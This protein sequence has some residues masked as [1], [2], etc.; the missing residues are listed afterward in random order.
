VRTV[1]EEIEKALYAIGAIAD[2]NY[3]DFKKIAFN[4]ATRT[5]KRVHALQNVFSCKVQMSKDEDEEIFRAKLNEKLPS[6]VRVFCVVRSSNRFNAKNCTSNREYSY[7]L[8]AFLLTRISDLY[9]GSGRN[10]RNGAQQIPGTTP[11]TTAQ[12]GGAGSTEQDNKE[13]QKQPSS[14]IKII[15]TETEGGQLYENPEAYLHVN[16]DHIPEEHYEK[17]YSY[18]LSEVDK[19]R[20][21]KIFKMFLGSKKYHNFSKEVKPHQTQAMR[22][23]VELSAND[24]MYIN[25][26][27]LEVT[28]ESDPK[29]I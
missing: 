25:R 12:E 3:G 14:G 20:V 29:S 22:F 7:Y 18:R 1:E 2:Y 8:P 6:D 10:N 16:I 28:D 17:L 4:R 27:T 11:S 5:D 23:M 19:E 15:K 9:F 21:Q 13:E 26:D 24:Y